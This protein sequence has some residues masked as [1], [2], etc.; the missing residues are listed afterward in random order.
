[1]SHLLHLVRADVRR[2]RLLFG[3]WTLVAIAETVLRAVRPALAGDPRLSMMF[4]LLA[5]VIFATRWLGIVVIVALVVQTHPLVGS[6]AFWMT[7]PIS[8][9]VLLASKVVLLGTIFVAVPALCELVLMVSCRVPMAE[10]LPVTLQ[11]ILFQCLWLFMVMALSS[12]TRNLARLA[13]VAGSVMIGL[14]LLLNLTIAVMMRRLDDGPQ[15]VEVIPR[16]ESSPIAFVLMLLLIIVAFS[17]LT[18]VQYRT[19]SIRTSVPAGVAGIGVAFAAAFLWPAA[20]RPVPVPDWAARDSSV[21]LSAE[22]ARGEFTPFES[23]SRWGRGDGWQVGR[24]RVR[25][26]ALEEGWLPTVKLKDAHIGFSDGATVPTSG[27]GSPPVFMSVNDSIDDGQRSAVQRRVLEVSRLLEGPAFPEYERS[28]PAIILT[29][30]EF[31]RRLGSRGTYRGSFVV[32]LDQLTLAATLPLQAGAT[33]HGRQKRLVLD[34]IVSQSRAATI[35]LRHFTSTSMFESA[36]RPRLLFYL[37]NRST[38]EAVAGSSH[39]MLGVGTGIGLPMLFGVSGY[40]SEPDSGFSIMSEV[41]RFPGAYG[42]YPGAASPIDITPEWLSQAELVVLHLI[43]AGSV[44][45]TLDV[46]GFEIAEAPARPP[47]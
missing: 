4:D 10:A 40:S 2:F 3:L 25:V 9:R 22:S 32:D 17:T 35:R 28:T 41:V 29:E 21:Q 16:T 11:L 24:A 46:T 12:L 44:S 38:S 1:M 23:G 7:R 27:N 33:Y 15:M 20:G 31:R 18:A 8:W 34:Q 47:G 19:R 45:R 14:I 26:G 30:P 5:T 42:R 39:G 36:M 37:R 13:L 43:P 6:D